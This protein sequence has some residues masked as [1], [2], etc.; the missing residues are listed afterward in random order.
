MASLLAHLEE[1]YRPSYLIISRIWGPPAASRPVS[2]KENMDP[3]LSAQ[4]QKNHLTPDPPASKK[5]VLIMLILCIIFPSTLSVP[6]R[7][8]LNITF[9]EACLGDAWLAFG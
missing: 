6:L 4:A 8:S 9:H 7:S 3:S 1:T 5:Q 2:P